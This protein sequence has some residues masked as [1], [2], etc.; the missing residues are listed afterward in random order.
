MPGEPR[1]DE[2]ED[3]AAEE[4]ENL[5]LEKAIEEAA[6]SELSRSEAGP[7]YSVLFGVDKNT[8]LDVDVFISRRFGKYQN[9]MAEGNVAGAGGAGNASKRRGGGGGRGA[10][11]RKSIFGFKEEWPK[12]PSFIGGGLGQKLV[13]GRYV[14]EESKEW[15]KTGSLFRIVREFGDINR[16]I[17]SIVLQ[18]GAP[19]SLLMLSKTFAVYGRMDRALDMVRRALYTYECA[20]PTSFSLQRF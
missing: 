1:K 18:R 16:A 4:E 20:S 14:F 10:L 5:L 19:E 15:K 2:E 17:S 12:P 6:A 11:A 7:A 3:L 13:D 8:L 9:A